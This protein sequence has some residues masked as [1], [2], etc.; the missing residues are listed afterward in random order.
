MNYRLKRVLLGKPLVTEQLSGE[1][2]NRPGPGRARARLH[3]VI[4]VRHRRDP[5]P[6]DALPSGLA[7]FALVVPIMFVIIGVLFF[8]TMSYLGRH[9]VLH[10]GRRLLR[11]RAR[12]L[13]AEDRSDRG[14]AGIALTASANVAAA[15]QRRN[16]GAAWSPTRL[17]VAP[18]CET[19]LRMRRSMTGAVCAGGRPTMTIACA[20]SRSAWL[21]PNI[22]AEHWRWRPVRQSRLSPPSA[23]TRA[24]E[25]RLFVRQA[26]AAERAARAGPA[27]TPRASRRPTSRS[28]LPRR[29]GP[30]VTWRS[31][32]A[33]QAAFVDRRK[34]RR[35]SGRDRTASRR[36]SRRLRERT[37]CAHVADALVDVHRTADAALRAGR[38]RAVIVPRPRLEAVRL[39]RQ[40]ADR[41]ELGHVAAEIRNVG[42][43]RG[44]RDDRVRAA[45][46]RAQ[47][48]LAGDDLVEAHAAQT[49]DATFFVEHDGRARGRRPSASAIWRRPSAMRPG[50][51]PSSSLADRTRR[52]CRRSDS[53]AGG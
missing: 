34:S 29:S 10:D 38:R 2:L 5:H 36:R 20:F 11:C 8:V 42:F 18:L 33:R 12:Q 17:S 15:I 49:Q 9:Q 3:L 43:A 22:A 21:P 7:A 31:S 28:H 14:R 4:G 32:G 40:R 52:P 19:A 25:K 35:C 16:G 26:A 48:L 37:S 47:R 46:V 27:S 13:R 53:P 50:R 30:F 39:R 1:R 45:V 23:R 51:R 41:A 44:R 24:G 6:D